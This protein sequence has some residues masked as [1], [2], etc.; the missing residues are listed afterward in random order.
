MSMTAADLSLANPFEEPVLRWD[1]DRTE[2]RRSLLIDATSYRPEPL[3][4][5]PPQVMPTT[6]LVSPSGRFSY[7][8]RI[9]PAGRIL[10]T[11]DP[12]GRQGTV[13]FTGDVVIP[14]LY[15]YAAFP[16]L[17]VWMSLTPMEIFTLRP[18]VRMARGKVVVAGLGLGWF[19]KKVHD[20][21]CVDE[22]VLIEKDRDLLDWYGHD[23]CGRLPKVADRQRIVES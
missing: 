13:R 6:Q 9:L 21:G 1:E 18:G 2:F 8:N 4:P 3:F 7:A 15:D 20:R 22:V 16:T 17:K 19:L 14:T 10:W 23:L 12:K 5:L 11:A